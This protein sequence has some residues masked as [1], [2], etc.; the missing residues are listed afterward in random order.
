MT[1]AGRFEGRLFSD[2]G[3]LHMVLDVN[4]ESGSA[5]VSYSDEGKPQVIEM[6]IG[7]LGLRL[8]NNPGLVLEGMNRTNPSSRLVQKTDG[9]FFTTREGLRGPHASEAEAEQALNEFKASA[10]GFG[11]RA[12]D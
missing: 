11:T 4:R 8:S 2:E 5:R 12:R 9:W 1:L 6:P 3:R 10:K 7:E